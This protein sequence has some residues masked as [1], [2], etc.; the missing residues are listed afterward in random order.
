MSGWKEVSLDKKKTR[1][2]RNYVMT[3]QKPEEEKYNHIFTQE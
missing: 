1:N 3:I 2:N